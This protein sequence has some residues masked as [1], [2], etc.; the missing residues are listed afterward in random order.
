VPAPSSFSFRSVAAVAL[1]GA[2]AAALLLVGCRGLVGR[3]PEAATGPVV[4]ADAARLPASDVLRRWDQA[5][6]QAFAEGDVVALRRLY[7]EGS[8]AGTSDARLL[9]AYLRKGL[10][11][12]GMRMQLLA[13]EVLDQDPR[14]LRVLVTDRLTGAVAVGRDSRTRLPRDQATTRVVELRRARPGSVWQVSAVSSA[15]RRAAR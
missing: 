13:L 9:R 12:E 3:P 7:V 8:D 10:R 15:P 1:L 4:T 11:V 5:R 6:S 14:R 2:L